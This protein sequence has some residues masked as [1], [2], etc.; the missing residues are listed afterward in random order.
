M[1]N[2]VS[3]NASISL[4]C[5]IIY[6]FLYFW[7]FIGT[8][9]YNDSLF[10]TICTVTKSTLEYKCTR[11]NR[12]TGVCIITYPF[13]KTTVNAYIIDNST[14]SQTD[15][16]NRIYQHDNLFNKFAETHPVGTVFNCFYDNHKGKI[17]FSKLDYLGFYI[18][19]YVFLGLTLLFVFVT[20]I[21]IVTK[22]P[23]K[24]MILN[25]FES[26][27]ALGSSRALRALQSSRA[28]QSLHSFDLT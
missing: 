9:K 21:L 8:Q 19:S 20:M 22:K 27:E 26:L 5:L 12:N 18:S 13:W 14:Y 17:L 24:D 2:C 10:S 28:P 1:I 4:I 6:L 16:S 25:I 11:F 23:F 3:F 15:S 7:G